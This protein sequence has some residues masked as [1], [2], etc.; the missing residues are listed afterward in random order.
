MLYTVDAMLC[1]VELVLYNSCDVLYAY[2]DK[3]TQGVRRIV[4]QKGQIKLGY[5][6]YMI[7][8][9]DTTY[10]TICAHSI[11]ICMQQGP[12]FTKRRRVTCITILIINPRRSVDYL[13]FVMGIPVPISLCLLSKECTSWWNTWKWFTVAQNHLQCGSVITLSPFSKYSQ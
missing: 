10:M 7:C 1:F 6:S 8:M 5:T 4:H 2:S 13:M 11:F 3:S 12:L 9:G